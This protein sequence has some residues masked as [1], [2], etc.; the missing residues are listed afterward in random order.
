MGKESGN[1]MLVKLVWN[2]KID[3]LFMDHGSTRFYYEQQKQ[4]KEDECEFWNS[5]W[6]AVT[7]SLN[8]YVG[9]VKFGDP[10]DIWIVSCQNFEDRTVT[11]VSNLNWEWRHLS[12]AFA[13]CDKHRWN[14]SPRFTQDIKLLSL[15]GPSLYFTFMFWMTRSQKK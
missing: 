10:T 13:S 4:M 6:N 11:S 2:N 3:T 14:H 8:Y 9:N 5:K 7:H 1:S 15:G 12:K